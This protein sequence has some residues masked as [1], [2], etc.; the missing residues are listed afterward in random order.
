MFRTLV[1]LVALALAAPVR[2]EPRAPACA[3]TSATAGLAACS[4]TPS[5]L[6]AAREPS[7][8]PSSS[9]SAG[10]SLGSAPSSA[11]PLTRARIRSATRS[12]GQTSQEEPSR[13]EAQAFRTALDQRDARALEH[14][15]ATSPR[16]VFRRALSVALERL[17]G[18]GVEGELAWL[19]DALGERRPARMLRTVLSLD[20]DERAACLDLRGE[21]TALATYAEPSLPD[22]AELDAL[23]GAC[24]ELQ[25]TALVLEPLAT[26]GHRLYL[27][28]RYDEADAIVARVASESARVGDPWK[29]S[30]AAEWLGQSDWRRGELAGATRWLERAAAV[31]R[32]NGSGAWEVKLLTDLATVALTRGDLDKSLRWTEQAE[33]CARPLGDAAALRRV[34]ATRAGLHFELGEHQRALELCHEV[35]PLGEDAPVQDEATVRADLLAASILSDVGRLESALTLLRRADTASRS[36]ALQ[37]LAPRLVEEVQLDLGLLLGDL[38]RTDE[39]LARLAEARELFRAIEDPRGVGWSWKNE[40]WV[41]LARGEHAA[42]TQALARARDVGRELD[43]PYLEALGALGVAEVELARA[44]AL[45]DPLL[46][47]ASV[48]SNLDVAAARAAALPVPQLLWRIDTARG[49]LLEHSGEAERALLAYTSAVERIEA[50]RRRIASPGLLAHALRARSDPYRAAAFLA[51]R[52]GRTEQAFAQTELLRGRVLA[53]QRRRRGG[54]IGQHEDPALRAACRRI[55]TLEFRMRASETTDDAR[56]SLARELTEAEARLDAALLAADVER[57]RAA[58]ERAPRT[59]SKAADTCERLAASELDIVVS[60]LVAETETLALVLRPGGTRA[61]LL[62]VTRDFIEERTARLRAPLQ[63]LRAGTLDLAHLGFD[64]RAARALYTALVTPLGLVPHEALGLVLDEPLADLPFE[65]LVRAGRAGPVD[66]ARPFAH[67][68]ELEF[69]ADA[70]DVVILSRAAAL[71]APLE[72]GRHGAIHVFRAP[73]AVGVPRAAEETAA[74]H[75]TFPTATIVSDARPEDVLRCEPGARGLHF[76]AHGRLDRDFPSH[77]HLVLGAHDATSDTARLEAW[78]IETRRF[79]ADWAVLSACDGAAGSWRTGEGL[80]GLTRAFRLAGC[81]RVIAGRWA[82]ED[83]S[84]ARFMSNLHRALA[85][86]ANPTAV[87][88]AARDELR[89]Q[90]A[91]AGPFAHPYFWA[92][93]VVHG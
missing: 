5:G 31:E 77:S 91:E 76:V 6:R 19:A 43:V 82:V 56:A 35:A 61:V 13:D 74:L 14:W 37:Q 70:H 25:A 36:Q 3:S 23:L 60:Y 64:V 80:F 59:P 34:L 67:W 12:A 90:E 72:H 39:G 9:S 53:E 62:P 24:E 55:A 73:E 44:R 52:L 46:D 51:A 30:W 86:G 47:T 68:N 8:A 84:S 49:A 71:P 66:P 81:K 18:G 63:A 11:L 88:R 32:A 87:L 83:A 75:T 92:A 42:A 48:R 29:E 40:G 65:L 1:P 10:T 22:A 15:A 26:L 33:E 7:R 2:C 93:W 50:W 38:G 27:A 58:Q 89:T 78:Q 28:G 69:L 45:S 54:D 41:R 85:N 57:G 20:D 21:L 79:D 17:A 4:A 16:D